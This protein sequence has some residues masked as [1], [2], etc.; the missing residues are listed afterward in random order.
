MNIG[1]DDIWR[2]WSALRRKE[3]ELKW[4]GYLPGSTT[5]QYDSMGR[6][7]IASSPLTSGWMDAQLGR[8]ER[9]RAA[10][11]KSGPLA[12]KIIIQTYSGINIS[13]I[14]GILVSACQDFALCYGGSGRKGR[15]GLRKWCGKDECKTEAL[16]MG[17]TNG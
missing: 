16:L 3:D 17:N 10:L 4:G 2:I 13:T 12:G 8:V 5:R 6:P 9:V 11:T 7:A 1:F 14:V 15:P